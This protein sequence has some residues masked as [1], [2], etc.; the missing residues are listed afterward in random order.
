MFWLSMVFILRVSLCNSQPEPL[1]AVSAR[2]YLLYAANPGEGFNLRRDVHMRVENLVRRLRKDEP[3]VLVLPPWPH[4]VHWRSNYPQGNIP[5]SM[6]FDLDSLNEYVP[7]I[8]YEDFLKEYGYEIDR[9]LYLQNYA[10]GWTSDTWEDKIDVRDCINNVPY[11]QDD[12]SE[13]WKRLGP[14]FSELRSKEFHCMSAQGFV[15]ILTSQLLGR[16]NER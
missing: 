14:T 10:E 2:K 7:S 3:W 9:I 4:L 6:F 5:W 8:E 1:Q 12:D 15:S 16:D 11:I 13:Q